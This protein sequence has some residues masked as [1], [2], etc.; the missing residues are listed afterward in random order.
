MGSAAQQYL[1]MTAAK[2]LTYFTFLLIA[3]TQRNN[4]PRIFVFD[5]TQTLEMCKYTNARLGPFLD[6]FLSKIITTT[7]SHYYHLLHHEYIFGSQGHKKTPV[8]QN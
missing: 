8:E 7:P 3:L 6:F 2:S 5:S 4:M 1:L